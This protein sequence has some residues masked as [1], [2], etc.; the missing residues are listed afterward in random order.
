LSGLSVADGSTGGL[1]LPVGLVI[2]GTGQ[3]MIAGPILV[4][5]LSRVDPQN[6]ADASG[7]LAK[8]IQLGLVLGVATFGSVYPSRPPS[9]DRVRLP[10][11]SRPRWAS[12]SSR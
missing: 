7:V 9:R 1:V 5:G 11:L 10:P 4:V 3:G 12:W 8:V 2:L 6:A